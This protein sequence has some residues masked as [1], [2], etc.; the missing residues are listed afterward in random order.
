MEEKKRVAR[1]WKK[2]ME[3]RRLEES[4][5]K[6]PAAIFEAQTN[7]A[8]RRWLARKGRGGVRNSKHIENR[9]QNIVSKY[10]TNPTICYFYYVSD[11]IKY[12]GE[13]Q[14]KASFDSIRGQGNEII[15][16]DYGSTDGTRSVAKEYGFQVLKIEKIKG[17]PF[18]MSKVINKIIHTSTSNFLVDL[19]IH[20]VYPKDMDNFFKG[21][22]KNNDV[23][24]KILN[25]RGLFREKNGEVSRKYTAS[26]LFYRPFLIEA[27]G[28]DERTFYANGTT[29][30][31]LALMNGVYKLDWINKKLDIIHE[32]HDEIK[33]PKKITMNMAM[34]NEHDRVIELGESLL[35]KLFKNFDQ[36]IKQVKNSYW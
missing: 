34:F 11:P 3:K 32:F 10:G 31:G 7:D 17:I 21:F 2:H 5:K 4:L 19:N 8:E 16:G 14:L 25:A 29:H 23:T 22:I 9:K 28:Y 6:F 27:R 33:Y 36:G 12:V 26:L 18:H 15:V 35:D 13:V 20:C 24:K 30:Y 1:E